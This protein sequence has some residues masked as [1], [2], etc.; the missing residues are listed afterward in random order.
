LAFTWNTAQEKLVKNALNIKFQDD[1]HVGYELT[2]DLEAL[3]TLNVQ[4]AFI[5][6]DKG[7]YFLKGNLKDK[8]FTVGTAQNILGWNVQVEADYDAKKE[9]QGAFGQPVVIRGVKEFELRRGMYFKV[10][11]T[12]G[13]DWLVE[14][15]WRQRVNDQLTF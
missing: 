1:I 11:E 7:T 6:K 15:S 5:N 2:H 12:F 9:L 8:L 10:K 14:T 4:T 3:K 13:K